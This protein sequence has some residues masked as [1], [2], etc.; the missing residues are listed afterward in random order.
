MKKYRLLKD[1]L[2]YE[3]GTT[4]V[5]KDHNGSHPEV[6]STASA[7]GAGL[8]VGRTYIDE[9][10]RSVNTTDRAWFEPVDETPKPW[11]ADPDGVYFYLDDEG[12]VHIARDACVSWDAG[13][14]K[15]GNYFRTEKQTHAASD[16]V[17][18]LL[19][20]IHT[21][22]PPGNRLYDDLSHAIN[23]ACQV[24]QKDQD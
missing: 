22:L 15:F 16:A 14:Y 1:L 12:D 17:K 9:M 13:R 4:F 19:E 24:V 5:V 21:E 2:G 8:S 3:A 11:R 20:Y 7:Q 6:V 18:L 10:M 23:T